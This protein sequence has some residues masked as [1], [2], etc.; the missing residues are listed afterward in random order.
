MGARNYHSSV[1]DA[2]V[3]R[4]RGGE[5]PT[6]LH[7]DTG[8]PIQ[9]LCRWRQAPSTLRLMPP[10]PPRPP[11]TPRSTRQWSVGEKLRVLMVVGQT[12]EGQ[13]GEVLRR[14]GVHDADLA[15]WRTELH[16]VLAAQAQA[17][18]ELSR[19]LAAAQKELQEVKA[20]L[21]LKKKVDAMFTPRAEAA[22]P[23]KSSGK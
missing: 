3:E 4:M 21:E 13:V 5:T 17:T 11:A 12:P 15:L 20:L 22:A 10:K 6:A 18:R 19:Q 23:P 1:R 9:T 2:L 8:I 16:E 14:E 7:W